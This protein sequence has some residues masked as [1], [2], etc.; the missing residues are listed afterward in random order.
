MLIKKI[1]T[2]FKNML[3]AQEQRDDKETEMLRLMFKE[4]Y[5]NLRALLSANQKA[6]FLMTDIEKALKTA[7]IIDMAF[8]KL[9]CTELIATVYRI[10]KSLDALAP[11]KY[12]TLY[13][14]FFNIKERITNILD[15]PALELTDKITLPLTDIDMNSA[16]YTG[17]KMASL[18]EIKKTTSLTVPEGFV[19]T[20]AGHRRFFKHNS[21][22]SEIE[23]R[24]QTCDK[25]NIE[26]LF[27]TC[28]SIQQLIIEA[29]LPE[30]MENE[31]IAAYEHLETKIGKNT[32]VCLRSSAIG[33][34]SLNA[35]FAGQYTSKLNV[36][37]QNILRS[38]KEVL[39]S[40]YNLTAF[41]YRLNRG[42]RDEDALMCVGCMRLINSKAGGVLYTADPMNQHKN[43]VIISSAWGLAKSVVDGATETDLFAVSKTTPHK[44]VEKQI[45]TK[46][47]KITPK[48]CEGLE[49]AAVTTEDATAQSLSD[50]EAVELAAAALNL[51]RIYKSPLDIEWAITN[52]STLYILQCRTLK[53]NRQ[54]AKA[55]N[56]TEQH[57][58]L[59]YYISGGI[60]ASPGVGYGTV[61]IVK[62]YADMLQFPPNSI[63]VTRQALPDWAALLGS[64]SAVIT[65]QGSAVCHLAN[66]AREFGAA[67]IFG[68]Q[69]ATELLSTGDEI[70]VDADELKIYKGKNEHIL[71]RKTVKD[72]SLE[73]LKNTAV[74]SVLTKIAQEIVPLS[75]I[76]PSALEF[77][78]DNCR[79]LHDITR[80]CHEKAVEEIFNFGKDHYFCERSSKQL[81]CGK[82]MN[83][84]IINLNDGFKTEPSGKYVNIE[85]IVSTPFLSLW[86]G[87]TAVIWHGPPLVDKSGFLSIL[88]QAA[89]N[90]YLDPTLM[91]N[92]ADK[93]YILLSKHFCSISSRL[94]FH[95][96]SVEALVG[97]RVGENYASFFFKGGAADTKRRSLRALFLAEILEEFGFK[98]KTAEDA[99]SARIDKEEEDYMKKRIKLL[100]YLIIHSR[101]LDMIMSNSA[102]VSK[103]RTK[104]L[105][106]MRSIISHV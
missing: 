5:Q 6:L 21:L 8:I 81:R 30:D 34:D 82:P 48:D 78:P 100:G 60:S 56:T 53:T 31:I 77:S 38:Y 1:K 51:E 67:A 14:V 59:D 70:T 63:L 72:R 88:H 36:S 76:N 12:K 25:N 16:G 29:S 45:R 69:K 104:M 58:S 86:E 7:E 64:A 33:E 4:R 98:T 75:L 15:D 18:G 102:S 91:S 35:S 39:A 89:S 73:N 27:K 85:N 3:G 23:R 68:L 99:L 103:Y 19:I 96:S 17:M 92:Y 9:R 10:I 32:K 93:N 55:A 105:A 11:E 20:S 26:E 95:L 71:K 24:I 52:D 62:K 13:N 74:F 37:P 65:E 47:G 54:T 106:D 94:G 46:T 44:I 43:C 87:I 49:N 57:S 2:V 97:E 50:T 22:Q 42:I 90:P 83:W 66:V 84:W 41:M 101:Q 40:K 80:Y 79:S 28:S 61:F